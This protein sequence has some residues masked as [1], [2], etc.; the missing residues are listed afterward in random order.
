MSGGVEVKEVLLKNIVPPGHQLRKAISEEGLEEL[1]SSIG[2]RGLLQRVRLRPNGE[3][4]EIVWGHRRFLAVE[5]LGWASIPAEVKVS[6]DSDTLLDSIHE[7]F[8]R[9]DMSPIEEGAACRRLMDEGG[10]ALEDVAKLVKKSVSWVLSRIDLLDLPQ[11]IQDAVDNGAL[12]IGA[13]RELGRIVEEDAQA[14]YLKYA[15]EQ[16]ATQKLCAFWRGRWEVEKI[17]HG[18][19]TEGE[20]AGMMPV[21]PMVVTM[22][23]W[24]CDHEI[25]ISLLNHFRACP[26]CSEHLTLEKGKTR[27]AEFEARQSAGI[28]S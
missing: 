3:K 22:P 8:H 19:T 4:F 16:G 15:I 10:Q 26:K 7:N 18:P 1:K 13:G 9:E 12:S 20:R 5:A 27:Q 2:K 17:V 14:H 28:E 11:A 23:C 25:P 24:F 21:P 6:S